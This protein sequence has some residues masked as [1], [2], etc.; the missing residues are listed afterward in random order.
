MI[1]VFVVIIQLGRIFSNKYCA[2][3]DRGTIF[4]MFRE[5]AEG[6]REA[7]AT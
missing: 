1:I 4:L 6:L 3:Q 5:G 2:V 7:I